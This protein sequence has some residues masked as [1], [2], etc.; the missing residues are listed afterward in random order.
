M[1][2]QWELDRQ[3][4]EDTARL[5]QTI[6][7]PENAYRQIGDR[8]D[9]LFPTEGL[10]TDLYETTGRGAISPLLLA[11]VTLLQM[12]EKAPDRQAAEWVVSRIDWKYALHLP[13]TYPGFHFTDLYA[14]RGRL[15]EHEQERQMFDEFLARLKALGL[16]KRRGK[17]RTDSTH[18]LAVV[19]QLSQLELVAESLRVALRAVS[20][21]SPEWVQQTL[22]PTFRD[23][24]SQRQSGY[25]LSDSEVQAHL[26]KAG[27]DGFW[28]LAQV[29]RSAP[30]SVRQLLEVEVLRTVLRQ[31]FPSGSGG[32][33]ATRRPTGGEVIESPHE[34][35]ARYGTKRGKGWIGYK[36]QITETCDEDQPHLIV[37]VAPTNALAN[38]S[39]ELPKIQ[40]RLQERDL[41]PGE[42]QVDQGYMSARR[43]AES[44]AVGINLMG[45]PLDDTQG[46]EGFRQADF[47]ID[48]AARQATCPA[49]NTSAVW[50]ESQTP[51]DPAPTI[52]LRFDAQ[53]CQHCR[54]F[55]HCTTSSQG[56]SLT[57]HPYRA[58]LAQRRAEAQTEEFKNKLH[59]RAGIESTISE[60]VRGHR[61]RWARYR[62]Q[63]K[64]GLQTYFTAAAVNLK[65][66]GRWW[67]R[68][69][70]ATAKADATA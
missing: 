18:L 53:T 14:F 33:P 58:L 16:I 12:L 44:A 20:E 1:S 60:L 42:Q 69:Q 70:P 21:A 32:P 45:V 5:G 13:L 48:E 25:G 67:T 23:E 24:C 46:P 35:E 10:F 6:L 7:A 66:V 65:R 57:L 9:E 38:D 39:P 52:K 40:T 28:F 43:I 26:V 30:E 17:M 56:R 50:S 55:G 3:V 51:G 68:P 61:L 8:F 4:P 64:L 15:L 63:A 62:G 59:L 37:D 47:D 36:A 34:P 29:D 49:E 2:L 19:E 22:P 11:L 41:L 54:F 27:Q 31:Q